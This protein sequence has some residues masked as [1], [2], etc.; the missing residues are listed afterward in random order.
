[1]GKGKMNFGI[2]FNKTKFYLVYSSAC[3]SF[4]NESPFEN[5]SKEVGW[6][7]L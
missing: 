6:K 1:M 3:L 5:L 4:C 7:F 2:D